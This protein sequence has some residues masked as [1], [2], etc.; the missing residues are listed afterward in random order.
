[1][2]QKQKKALKVNFDTDVSVNLIDIAHLELHPA[3][4]RPTGR[5]FIFGLSEAE[6]APLHQQHRIY[7]EG[8]GNH[9]LIQ[10]LVN[11]GII[12]SL[13]FYQNI[14]SSCPNSDDWPS[15]IKD[16]TGL[17]IDMDEVPFQ[18]SI[19]D[20]DHVDLLKEQETL[21]IKDTSSSS[22]HRIDFVNETMEFTRTLND[23]STTEL[24]RAVVEVN[25]QDGEASLSFYVG[26]NLHPSVLTLLGY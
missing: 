8:D 23:G 1:M 10:F 17:T 11:D 9:Y 12:E 16:I 6:L 2:S 13:Q 22:I 3:F 5:L 19:G 4:V 26:V 25:N 24:L 15:V 20:A 18:R 14:G 21:E 7:V